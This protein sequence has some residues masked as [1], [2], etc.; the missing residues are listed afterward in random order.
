MT[1]L[2]TLYEEVLKQQDTSIGKT[3]GTSRYLHR[4][5]ICAKL[6]ELIA[7][8]SKELDF[9]LEKINIIRIAPNTNKLSLMEYESFWTEGFPSLKKSYTITLSP[10]SIST[11]QHGRNGNPPILHRKELFI[12]P[13]HSSYQVFQALTKQAEEYGLFKNTNKIGYK[14]YWEELLKDKGLIVKGNNL[15]SQG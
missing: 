12:S 3:V 2:L 7:L 1:Q 14:K 8:L 11:R 4:T 15:I 6:K 5:T 10:L 13:E 9:S